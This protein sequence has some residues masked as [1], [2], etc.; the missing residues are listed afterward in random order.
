MEV[1][2]GGRKEEGEAGKDEWEAVGRVRRQGGEVG[3]R[4]G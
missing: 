3:R 4:V 2:L 1:E